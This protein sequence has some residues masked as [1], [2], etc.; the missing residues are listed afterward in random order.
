MSSIGNLGLGFGPTGGGACDYPAQTTVVAG[1]SYAFGAQT[2]NVVVPPQSKV[3]QGE[4]YGANG[5]Q[6]IGSLVKSRGVVILKESPKGV[7]PSAS[8]LQIATQGINPW[9]LIASFRNY[10]M[11]TTGLA[12]RLV[13]VWFGDSRPHLNGADFFIWFRPLLEAPD[14]SLG[15]GRW[16]NRSNVRMELH[17][18]YRNFSDQSQIDE[19][20]GQTYFVTHWKLQQALQGCNLFDAYTA[21][22]EK[23]NW[24][25]PQPDSENPPLTVEPMYLEELPVP[26]K[27]QKEEGTL[28]GILNVNLPVVL[29]L[30]V[31]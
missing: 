1:T 4:S 28:E 5:T 14:K 16:G 24:Y 23:G 20:R 11:L 13:R 2:G 31:P 10:V 3:E 30:T 15:P 25:P 8:G 29:A 9:N 19:T 18:V 17:L 22:P 6:Y 7:T 26:S 27:T 12:E 21:P